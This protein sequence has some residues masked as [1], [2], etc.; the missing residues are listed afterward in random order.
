MSSNNSNENLVK[1]HITNKKITEE[2]VLNP[3][4]KDLKCK[5]INNKCVDKYYC[6]IYNPSIY[7]DKLKELGLSNDVISRFDNVPKY[8]CCNV[9]SISLYLKES[10][11]I[12]DDNKR[13]NYYILKTLPSIYATIKNVEKNLPNWIVRV[14]FDKSVYRCLEN[15]ENEIKKNK[16]KDEKDKINLK[17]EEFL[18]E[19]YQEILISPNV[20]IYTYLCEDINISKTRTYRFLTMI[21]ED[22]NLYVIREADGIVSNLDCHNIKIY[23]ESK[24]KL[25]YLVDF[26]NNNILSENKIYSQFCKL[27]PL[28][29]SKA[30]LDYLIENKGENGM[31]NYNSYAAWLFLYKYLIENEFFKN[32]Q[33]IYDLLAGAFSFK[34]KINKEFYY[35]KIN[36]LHI[37]IESLEKIFQIEE[38]DIKK[39]IETYN[40]FFKD[41]PFTDISFFNPNLNSLFVDLFGSFITEKDDYT[42]E[43]LFERK[44]LFFKHLIIIDNVL[45]IG[46]DEIL[47]LDIFK[48]LISIDI[49]S[50]KL[51]KSEEYKKYRYN[52]P[53]SNEIYKLNY[54]INIEKLNTIKN[55]FLCDEYDEKININIDN[56]I[57]TNKLT[58]TIFNENIYNKISHILKCN[59]LNTINIEDLNKQEEKIKIQKQN[60][61]DIIYLTDLLL[62]HKNIKENNKF[63]NIIIKR[64]DGFDIN[65]NGLIVHLLNTPFCLEIT[66]Y[67]KLSSWYCINYYLDKDIISCNSQKPLIEGGKIIRNKKYQRKSNKLKKSNRSKKA[68]KSKKSNRSKKE[69]KSKKS[70]KQNRKSNRS[71]YRK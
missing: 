10:C 37:K 38:S 29:Y 41:Y 22:V 71:Q 39:N 63:F 25:F 13:N 12:E 66:K 20:E 17:N 4:V 61:K 27:K 18:Y 9:I 53:P 15:I 2:E 36:N 65:T 21:D 57:V 68:N 42:E 59:T 1:R 28:S 55:I 52:Y 49:T 31:A 69:N 8:N 24:D 67:K 64:I 58:N 47:L 50:D 60:E 48:E 19:R 26:D 3:I 7:I 23:E 32:K 11:E 43:L 5:L 34:L 62:S 46:F 30:G 14:Y 54:P 51:E 45:N 33:N 44:I 35:D 40:K 56:T 16:E 6:H 70:K